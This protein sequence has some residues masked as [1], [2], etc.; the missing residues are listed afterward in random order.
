[1]TDQWGEALTD[2]PPRHDFATGGDLVGTLISAETRTLNDPNNVGSKKD[3][4]LYTFGKDDSSKVCIWGSAQL[5]QIL[6]NHI[7]HRVKVVDTGTKED[8]GGG[9]QVRKFN[10]FCA[11]CASAS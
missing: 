11:T 1:M 8:I 9:R 10:V 5:V 2:I 3:T 4:E 6:P 7:G